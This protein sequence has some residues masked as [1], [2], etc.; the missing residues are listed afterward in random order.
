M[1]TST[2]NATSYYIPATKLSAL[3][4]W[5]RVLQASHIQ[6]KQCSS[7]SWHFQ[8]FPCWYTASLLLGFLFSVTGNLTTQL[9]ASSDTIVSESSLMLSQDPLWPFCPLI[10]HLPL[11]K[12]RVAQGLPMFPIAFRR[13][14]KSLPV[15]LSIHSRVDSAYSSTSS[16]ARFIAF[17][18][19]ALALR[20]LH[21]FFLELPGT[22]PAQSL[23][24]FGLLFRGWHYKVVGY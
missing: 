20:A 16:H 24:L 8:T 5:T 18:H 2:S 12:Q 19:N 15:D 21:F 22:F 1:K 13:K 3:H 6:P 14:S 11:L 10:L 17:A 7:S 23:F 9:L 4:M